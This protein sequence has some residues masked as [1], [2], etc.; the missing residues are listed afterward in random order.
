[1]GFTDKIQK[2]PSKTRTLGFFAAVGVVVVLFIWQVH[3]P[4]TAQIKQLETTVAGLQATI[5]ENDAKIKKLDEL[6]AE[7][8]ALH[9]RL[10]VLTE[11]LPPETEVSGLLRQ[12]QNLVNQSGLILKLWKP[13]KRK[14]HESGLYDEIPIVLEISGGYHN[15]GV[16]FDKVSKLTRIV[17][18]MNLKMD[19]AKL[20][21]N[22]LIDIKIS[23]TAM[24]F[25]AVEKKVEVAPTAKK[26]Q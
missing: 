2:I 23:C 9:E 5:K 18:I 11:Q 6:K 13:E 1:M 15:V 7:V 20:Q 17:N 19:S 8:K 10:R 12:L 3:I 24:T 21:K 25:A 14:P 26:V 4:K 22:G 16:F